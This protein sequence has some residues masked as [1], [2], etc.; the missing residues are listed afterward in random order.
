MQGLIEK[1]QQ[2]SGNQ[3]MIKSTNSHYQPINGGF[4]MFTHKVFSHWALVSLLGLGIL[5]STSSAHATQRFLGTWQGLYPD[6]QSDN[7]A[8][9]VLCHITPNGDGFN[10]Y[11]VEVWIEGISGAES[12]D[13]DEDPTGSSNITEIN[14]NTQPGWAEGDNPDGVTG[15]LDPVAGG[16]PPVA[17]ANGPYSALVDESITFD[18]TGSSDPD[19]DATIASYEWNFGDGNTGTG[20]TPTHSYAAAGTYNVSLVVTDDTGLTGSDSSTATISDQPQPPVADANGPY[21]ALVGVSI[22]FDGTGSSDPDGTIVSYAWDFGD[23]NTG[24]GATPSHAYAAAAVYN[25]SLVVT[26]NDGLTG[27]ASSTATIN[28]L[29]QPPVADANGPYSALVGESITFDGTGSSDPDGTIVSYAW[30][31]G[32][33]NTGT[34]ATPTHSY[35]AVGVY[36]VSLVVTDNDGNTDSATSTAT[37]SDIPQELPVADANGPYSALV[38]DSITFDGT[39]SS[40]P[41]GTIVSYAWDFGDGNTGSGATPSHSYAAAG[42][43]NVSLVVT[44]NDGNTDSATSTATISDPPQPPVA[45]A[46]GPYSALVDESITFDGTGSSDPDG[47]IVSYAWDFGDGNTGTGATPTHAYA[48]AAVYNVS[49][50]V[51]DNDGNTH[52]A[53]STATIS[54]PP[55][56]PVADANGP[57][58]GLVE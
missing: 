33:G 23:G 42:T 39:G 14:A 47:T 12:F 16:E 2:N 56:A 25:V 8:G 22:T 10:P 9:C 41:D 45:D 54:D 43:Y 24:S 37:I 55:Q 49:L 4:K 29:P 18:G 27:S 21:S 19:G 52:S 32:D 34:G 20:A 17:D 7:N 3:Q 26:D 53:T 50:V 11:G 46:N 44:D 48:V 5:L 51:T 30:N 15:D 40:D 6:S 1:L 13:S 58:S 28:D 57:Y 31:F 38:G 35:T 36:N